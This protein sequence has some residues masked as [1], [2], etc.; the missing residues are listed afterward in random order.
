MA[1]LIRLAANFKTRAVHMGSHITDGQAQGNKMKHE[2]GFAPILSESEMLAE[3][4][5]FLW[6][7]EQPPAL[8]GIGLSGGGVRAATVALGVLQV[9]AAK[10]LLTRFQYIS[11]VSGGGYIASALSWFWSARRVKEERELSRE[12]IFRFGAD[13]E[14]FPFQDREDSEDPG[15]ARQQQAARN[16]QFLRNHGSYL[17][18]G[19]GIGFAGLIIAVLRTILA[20]LAVWIP[21][22][23]SMFGAIDYFDD[24][25]AEPPTS[26]CRV[27]RIQFDECNPVLRT[28][29]AHPSY[30]LVF[31]G[32]CFF[33]LL[34]F[35][36]VILLSILSRIQPDSA[37]PVTTRRT[38]IGL[39]AAYSVAAVLLLCVTVSNFM[40]LDT[41]QPLM[42]V[43]LLFLGL[44]AIGL[45]MLAAAEFFGPTNR[46]YFLRRTFEKLSGF[47]LPNVIAAL[48]L[49]ALPL[50]VLGT[51]DA[52]GAVSPSDS[53]ASSSS[54]LLSSL[55]GVVSLLS[56]VGTAL[57]GY[58]MKAKSLLPGPAG[59][60]LA[61]LGSILFLS[62]ILLF[63]FVLAQAI[64][65]MDNDLYAIPFMSLFLIA[66]TLGLFSSVNAT[67]LHRFYRDRL[68]ETF[69]PM[70]SAI[71]QGSAR[72]TDVADNFSIAHIVRTPEE[73]GNRPYHLVNAHA[74]LVNDPEAKVAVRGG[75]NFIMSAA[76]VG[77]SA[78][79][80]MKTSDY[81]KR[82]GPLTLATA[83]A[84]SGAAA[85]ANAGYIGAGLTRERFLSAVMALLN[86]RLGVWVGN[87]SA[88]ADPPAGLALARRFP[89]P[90]RVQLKVPT[91]FRPV[92]PSGIFGFGHHRK[93]AFL[94]LS[95]GGHFENLGLY[96]LIRRKLR[97]VLVVDAEEDSSINLAALVSSRNR[98]REDFGATIN[99]LNGRGPEQLLGHD[100]EDYPSGARIA[101][102]PFIVGE[103]RYRDG[104][105]GTLI[106][107]KAT[108]WS[109]LD[110]A[111]KGYR[112]ANPDFP[113]QST[114]DQFFNP[115]QFE[116]YRDLGKK[117]CAW[118]IDKLDLS[119]NFED[120][121]TLLTS[122]G[123]ESDPVEL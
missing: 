51:P 5:L 3:E 117:S 20:S 32:A 31:S 34:F 98:I 44:A 23:V 94:E 33:I 83:M 50:I 22:L 104:A 14:D 11:S 68:M 75:D 63:S 6:G 89:R 97:L 10:G 111:T 65:S 64:Y 7:R 105:R 81:L 107:I 93:A 100:S 43:A 121:S 87:P 85:N 48:F 92:L 29:Q 54:A 112:A 66:C 27:L 19:D 38:R 101:K 61:L 46:G 95:D 74:I 109:D 91:Y 86:I 2:E 41:V 118:M 71:K 119:A 58:Y 47:V 69:M 25:L 102:S 72:E 114:V 45:I 42:G 15:G 39:V 67:G 82:N 80:W 84:V 28:M 56:G 36:G 18:S 113:H 77:S 26:D 96:E 30:A 88:I 37:I 53:A 115:D 1:G 24:W 35:F 55:G 79:G 16:L 73:R 116:A 21:L 110:F 57:Y 49:G 108:M 70:A 120:T 9:L 62:G 13:R 59:L 12:V 4:S 103:I 8:A 76:I 123:F 78:T 60:A 99:F 52:G 17:T 106:Y 90:R 122:Y 40:S